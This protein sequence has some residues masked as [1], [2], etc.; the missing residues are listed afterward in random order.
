MTFQTEPPQVARAREA[1]M[2][3]NIV[4]G[5]LVDRVLGCVAAR[6]ANKFFFEDKCISTMP[7]GRVEITSTQNFP[8]N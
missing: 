4:T 8:D 5:D 2:A 3:Q 1:L 7:D 6:R